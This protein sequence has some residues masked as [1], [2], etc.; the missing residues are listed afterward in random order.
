MRI[1]VAGAG[2]VGSYFGGRLAEAGVA[3]TFLVREGRAR[4]LEQ[5]GLVVHSTHGDIRRR[6]EFV[7]P[8]ELA[9]TFDLVMLCCK[10]YQLEGLVADL[11]PAIGPQ[12]VVL[13]LLNGLRH[14]EYLDA[15][16]PSASRRLRGSSPPA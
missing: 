9:Q 2:G 6:V 12:T 15:R 13:P 7:R 10:A 8:G 1:L 5:Q 3:V 14:L 16:L 4:Q 11:K